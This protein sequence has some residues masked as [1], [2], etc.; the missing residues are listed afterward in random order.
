M[1]HELE[2]LLGV[3]GIGAQLAFRKGDALADLF[4]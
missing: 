2:L 1:L 4:S 3:A